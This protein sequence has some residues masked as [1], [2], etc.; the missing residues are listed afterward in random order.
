MIAGRYPATLELAGGRALPRRRRSRFP[1]GAAR[2]AA[3]ALGVD[4][5]ARL[6]SL[7]GVCLPS[8][9]LGPLLILV[10]SIEL[11]WLPVSGRG[12]L[13]HLVLPA[14]DAR[15]RHGRHPRPPDAHERARGARARTTCAR[16][17]PRARPSG[18]WSPC[19]RSGT[20][21]SRSSTVVG[22]QAGAL[23]AGADHHRDDLRLARPRTARRPGDR[24]ARLSAGAG[25]RAR[26]SACTYVVVNTATDLL[27]RCARPAAPRCGVGA[28]AASPTRRGLAARGHR[29]RSAPPRRSSR[30]RPVRDRP[31]RRGSARRRRRTSSARTRSA[32]TSSRASSTARASRFV[33]GGSR[34]SSLSP[35]PASRSAPSP[36]TRGGWVDEV[37]ARVIDVAA[38]LPRPAARHRARRRARAEPPERRPRAQPPRLDGLRAPRARRGAPRSGSATSS[39]P[40][41]R[42]ARARCGVIVRH[43]LPLAAPA[44]L[45]QATF[46]LAGAIVAEASLSFLGLGAPAAAAVVGCHARRGPAVPPRRAAPDP[47]PG[48]R[49]RRDRARAPAP[50]RRAPR[51]CSTCATN[52]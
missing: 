6:A 21:S 44:L 13:A 47:L 29:P 38:R 25:L 39:R 20:R 4:R 24:R 16:R 51:R 18:G 12:G 32:A 35:S 15:A 42:S 43:L 27:H 50:R 23:L 28:A 17:A 8:F 41:R 19:T 34:R 22:L 30:R 26:R 49:A 1:L 46:G 37:L 2:G 36:A 5:A 11:G 48:P 40:R 52:P 33:V 31:R 14:A 45:V 9:W 7:A 10:F 3:A